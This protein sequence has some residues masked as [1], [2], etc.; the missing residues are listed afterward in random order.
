MKKILT[1]FFVLLFA[2]LPSTAVFSQTRDTVNVPSQDSQGMI[3][4]LQRFILGDTTATGERNNINRVY[5]LI[6]GE[7]Y[8]LSSRTYFEFPINMTADDGPTTIAPPVI[9]PFPLSDG[10]VPRITFTV[11]KDAYFKNIY[12]CGFTPNEMQ[13]RNDRPFTIGG[14]GTRLV[15]ENCICDNF[16]NG[17]LWNAGSHTKLY[18]KDCL[19]RNCFVDQ[20][21]YG[22]ILINAS[23]PMDTVSLVNTTQFNGSSYLMSIANQYTEYLRV[24][25]CTVFITKVNPF[26]TPILTNADIKN[27]IFMSCDMAGE[28]EFERKNSWYNGDGER[29]PILF[30]DTIPSDIANTYGV[31]NANKRINLSNNA[32][33][34][35]QS[36]KDY[37]A[38]NDTVDA[39]VFIDDRTKGMFD[40]DAEYPNM[41]AENNIE[42]DPGYN[43]SVMSQVDSA[44]AWV[45]AFRSNGTLRAYNYNPSGGTIFPGVWPIPEDLSYTNTTLQHAGSD[46]FAIGDLN[47]FPEQKAQWL[48]TDVNENVKTIPLSMKLSQN[49]PS[50]FNPNTTITFELP[51]S[52]IVALK[53]YDVLGKEVKTLINHEMIAGS[54]KVDFI[55][56]GLSSGIY[57]Y[58]LTSDNS[59]IVKKMML[60]K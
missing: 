2:L 57:Y 44:L 46:G 4:A 45:K 29:M 13:S 33:F 31:T 19:M 60:M 11:N 15:L 14:E 59:T 12:W 35:T 34:W 40:K 26:E 25:H 21:W 27:N 38:S 32:Y 39:P 9:A 20:E 48:L 51:K 41:V 24:E 43:S 22:Q 8:L 16:Y 3:G 37:W 10:S 52:G 30:L 47:W 23:A 6:R 5:R 49:Y 54:H 42:A 55:A 53:V 28:T 56:N 18:L 58:K 17:W 1:V 50:P 7:R 36:L